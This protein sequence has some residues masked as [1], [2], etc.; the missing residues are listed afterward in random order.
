MQSTRCP[1]CEGK[2]ERGFM[3]DAAANSSYAPPRWAPGQPE[4]SFWTGLKVDLKTALPV[5]TLRC[6]RCGF[7][8]SYAAPSA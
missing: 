6:T 1:K 8:E 3:V 4:K 7:L 5:V 2:M